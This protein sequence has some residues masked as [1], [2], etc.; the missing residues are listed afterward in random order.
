MVTM[1]GGPDMMGSIIED[2]YDIGHQCL[3]KLSEFEPCVMIVVVKILK[4]WQYRQELWSSI[5]SVHDCTCVC[6][7]LYLKAGPDLSLSYILEMP[8]PL[9]LE[10]PMGSW[11]GKLKYMIWY[12]Y[13]RGCR[14]ALVGIIHGTTSMPNHS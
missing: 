2:N 11:D 6:G 5:T 7:Y 14:H 9:F 1:Q 8:L 13:T 4:Q 10:A 3:G 12:L